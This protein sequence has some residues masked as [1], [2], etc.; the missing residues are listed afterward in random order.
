MSLH[1]SVRRGMAVVVI[2]AAAMAAVT[3]GGVAAT[4]APRPDVTTVKRQVDALR[5]EAEE[6]TE[7]YNGS[8]EKLKSVTV[9]IKAATNRVE[10]Q[11]QSV[12]VARRALGRIAAETY[13]A[14]DLELVSLL[15]DD[16]PESVLAASGLRSSLGERQA[17]AVAQLVAAQQRLQADKTTLA[18]QHKQLADETARLGKLKQTIDDKLDDAERLLAR[19]D[20]SEQRAIA[21]LGASMNRNDLEQ[22]GVKVPATGML[23]CDDVGIVTSSAKVR[24]ALA[25]A[26]AQIGKPY[27][28]G[29]D[30]PGSYDCSG[31]SMA[32][33][34]KAGISLPHN[35]A[36]QAREGTAVP[37]SDLQAGDLLFFNNYNHMG[38]YVGKGLMVHAPSTGDV[39]RIASARL[40]GRL[41]K[42]V[43]L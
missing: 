37:Q 35:A 1:W 14:G 41:I 27:R 19:L 33:W 8:R 2:T 42:A 21:R 34:A 15:L 9:M 25:F 23:S 38:I 4:A 26:C 40:D 29:G 6:A 31:L 7:Q 11:Q 17:E 43:R 30:G 36:M 16:D 13:K 28:W 18:R 39:V 24:T 20:G 5:H 3:A 12:D 32:A 22:A 10:Q